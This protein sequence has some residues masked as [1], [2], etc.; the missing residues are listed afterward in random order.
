MTPLDLEPLALEPDDI[1]EALPTIAVPPA[2]ATTL[3]LAD[4]LPADVPLPALTRFVPD[5][6]LRTSAEEAARYALAVDVTGPEGLERADRAL[7]VLRERQKA[8]GEHFGEPVEIANRLHKRLTALRKEWTAAGEAAIETVGRRV[9]AEDK[10]LKDVAAEVQRKAQAEADRQ[11]RERLQREADAAAK[12][13]AP[14]PIVEELKRQAATATAP[15]VAPVTTAPVMRGTSTMTTWKARP[16]ET[17]A[18]AEPNPKI[19]EMSAPQLARVKELLADILA[20]K[21]PITAIEINY[22]VLNARAKSDKK[23]F[24]IAGF[25]AVEVGSIRA[26]AATR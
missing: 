16:K 2:P 7:T 15:P 8:I 26:K 21:A 10:R 24:A 5:V 19:A 3:P 17:P 1:D 23:T 22:T 18:E 13:Q 25:E 6:A 12:Q 11:E 4:V 20:D 14:A 9:W